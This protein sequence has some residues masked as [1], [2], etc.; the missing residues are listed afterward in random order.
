[1]SSLPILTLDELL[2]KELAL[3]YY[4]DYL[5]IMNLQKY[6]IFYLVAQG[7]F[8]HAREKIKNKTSRSSSN[9]PLFPIP[10]WKSTASRCLLEIQTAKTKNSREDTF[11]ML[12]DK[13]SD[14]SKD[15]LMP[16]APH[17]LNIDSGLIETLSIRIKNATITPDTTWFDSMCKY[18]YEKMKNEDIF[19][20]NFY[21]S[22]AY[23][24]L[25]LELEFCSNQGESTDLE[26]HISHTSV[27]T[28]S[29]GSDSNSGDIQFDDDFEMDIECLG[30]NAVVGMSGASAKSETS[31]KTVTSDPL[32]GTTYDLCVM[33][34][35]GVA[36]ASGSGQ[37]HLDVG[38]FK[39][40]R[41]HSDCTGISQNMPDVNVA[42]LQVGAE[43]RRPHS[44]GK[45]SPLAAKST[46]IDI[47][48]ALPNINIAAIDHS[49]YQQRL[50]AKIINTAINCD[51]QYAVYAIQVTVIEDNQ[52]KSWHVYRRYSRFLDLKKLLVKRVCVRM[53]FK[54]LHMRL[55]MSSFQQYFQY[56]SIAQVPFPAKKA[57]QNTQRSVLEHRMTVLNEF[58]KIVCSRADDNEDLNT[59]LRDFLEPD[60]NDKKI[61][62]GAVVRT[63][64]SIIIQ[65]I[66]MIN[67]N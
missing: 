24:K 54:Y 27:D 30:Q 18:V 57:F 55:L 33:P 52:H 21:Q 61:H 25:L 10:E 19:L 1:M 67:M 50:A 39:H 12:R 22:T 59:M 36:A 16:T 64:N 11:R 53:S 5:S 46:E 44:A 60:T 8:V 13:A 23:R 63:V 37:K 9:T 15:Y 45:T 4:L 35:I 38:P 2:T 28:G 26:S 29:A 20:H 62:G 42:L 41:S 47:S 58:L 34:L 40:S 31:D 14:I 66:N 3:S 48:S 43:V 49:K 6:V 65:S 56:P 51:G 17:L 32:I 7:E